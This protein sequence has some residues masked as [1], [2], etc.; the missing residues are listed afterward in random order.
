[1]ARLTAARRRRR[2]RSSCKPC[3]PRCPRRRASWQPKGKGGTG[4]GGCSRIG[5]SRTSCCCCCSYCCCCRSSRCCS[6]YCSG[7]CCHCCCHGRQGKHPISHQENA[8][9]PSHEHDHCQSSLVVVPIALTTAVLDA[10]G[11]PPTAPQILPQPPKGLHDQ[12][13]CG[14]WC[15]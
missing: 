15:I 14:Y 7:C 1:M 5:V 10:T 11:M 13:C 3:S 12:L 2:P 9:A 6:C 8:P 4:S